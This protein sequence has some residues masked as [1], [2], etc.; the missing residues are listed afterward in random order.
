MESAEQIVGSGR[1]LVLDGGLSTQLELGGAD[2]KNTLWSASVLLDDPA[3]V[4]AAHRA[5]VDAGLRSEA[6]FV[7][8][9]L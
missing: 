4:L 7:E 2:L 3:A 6:K 1:T 8:A 5:F 9:G